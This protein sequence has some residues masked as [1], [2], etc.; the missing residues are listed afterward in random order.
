MKQFGDLRCPRCGGTNVS[1]HMTPLMP[2]VEAD[3]WAPVR[4]ESYQCSDCRLLESKLNNADDYEEFRNRWNDPFKIMTPEELQASSE[5][6]QRL[7]EERD[8]SWTWPLEDLVTD[9]E[10]RA[11]KLTEERRHSD[12]M[13][14]AAQQQGLELP[15]YKYGFPVGE[16]Y[17]ARVLKRPDEDA[18]RS[19]YAEWLRVYDTEA[20]RNSAEFVEWQLRLA[21]TLRADPRADIR[22]QLPDGVFSPREPGPD[23]LPDQPW[24]RY[25]GGDCKYGRIPGTGEKGLGESIK[26]LI[27]E[28]LIDRSQYFRGFVE[29]VAI[30][31]ARFLEIADELYGLAPIRHLTLTYCKGL[32]HQDQGLW[33]ALLESPHLDR[34]RSLRIPVRAFGMDNEYTVLNRL[35]DE[36]LERLAASAHLQGLAYLDLEDADRLTVRAFDALAASPSLPAL[37]FVRHD[38]HRYGRAA[39]FTFGDFGKDVREL[40]DRPL[41]RYAPELEARHGRIVWLHPVENYGTETP[42]LEAVVEHPVAK[43]GSRR[44]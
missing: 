10:Q 22:P 21:E 43:L 23:D 4:E 6:L 35:A 11:I 27:A 2:Q 9:R 25:P 17:I 40:V 24:W 32:D 41:A 8:R 31:A 12:Y 16:E 1:P 14:W 28:G 13:I 38:L 42:D 33:E 3:I 7:Y 18:P 20:A 26:V 5:E 39:S 29:H 34:I 30:R 44:A 36:D 37:S 15:E 19:E